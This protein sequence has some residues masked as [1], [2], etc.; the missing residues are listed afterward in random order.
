MKA[1]VLVLSAMVLLVACAGCVRRDGRNTDC[2]WPGEPGAKVLDPSQ[3]ATSRHLSTDLEFAEELAD[4]YTNVHY[5][6]R[7]GYTGP[8]I[9][10]KM[11]AACL[12]KLADEIGK[13]HGVSHEVMVASFG[14]N[15]GWID[16]TEIGSFA[17][18]FT[19][20]AVV[21]ARKLWARYPPSEE[22]AT[23]L[24]LALVCS[25]GF[26]VAAVMLGQQWNALGEN[27]RIGTGHLGPRVERLPMVRH[28]GWVFAGGVVLFWAVAAVLRPGV[29]EESTS[30]VADALPP[31]N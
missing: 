25:I 5:G 7:S 12:A 1:R 8:P 11:R 15:R 13:Q 2:V 9:A 27:L 14:K 6:P 22:L 23:G 18:L 24:V 19:A 3:P 21:V 4:R 20:L 10:G 16:A 28:A 26:G 31:K 29:A 30:E 17:L